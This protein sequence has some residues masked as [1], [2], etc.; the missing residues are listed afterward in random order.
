M[1]QV[2]TAERRKLYFSLLMP[3]N[4]S[5]AGLLYEP[6]RRFSLR[7]KQV[8]GLEMV[9]LLIWLTLLPSVLVQAK[10]ED[11]LVV[12]DLPDVFAKISGSVVFTN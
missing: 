2:S 3:T 5:F 9:L 7:F 8:S 4:S 10:L 11:I 12:L 6:F 1:V